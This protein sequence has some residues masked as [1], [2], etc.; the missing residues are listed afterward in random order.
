MKLK[1]IIAILP[2]AAL[3]A[4]TSP[5][6]NPSPVPPDPIEVPGEG[7]TPDYST[8]FTPSYNYDIVPYGGEVAA[9]APQ[10]PA[11]DDGL[12]P[13]LTPWKYIVDVK[14]DGLSTPDVR[15]QTGC[16]ATVSIA[17][18]DVDLNLGD[19]DYIKVVVHG[20]CDAGSLRISGNRRHMLQLNDLHLASTDRPAINDQN[21]KRVF[22]ELVGQT[23][24]ADGREYAAVPSGE[25]R[26][27]CFFAEGNVVV[28]GDGVLTLRGNYSHGFATDGF[29]FVNSGATLAVT[30]AVRNAIHVKGSSSE[31]NAF[32]GVEIVGGYV[33]AN[34]SAPRGKAM[35]SDSNIVIRGGEVNLNCSGDAA[36]D[37][38]DGSL[39]SAACIKSD[40][41]VQISGGAVSLTATGNGAKG[42][43][44][45]GSVT[46][47][48]GE[49]TVALSGDAM[50]GGGDSATPKGIKADGNMMINGGGNYVSARGIGGVGIEAG[51]NLEI[52]GGVTYTFGP[53]QGICCGGKPVY[54]GT[55]VLLAGGLRNA[56]FPG[57]LE[58][59]LT[60]VP[61]LTVS[62]IMSENGKKLLG[63]FRWPVAMKSASLIFLEPTATV[64]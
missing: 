1:K 43:K 33:Y 45:N 56:R 47:S 59:T 46:L 34:T 30:D 32:R 4:C 29:L 42:I 23:T 63:S 3:G 21:G 62:S 11:A 22:L 20:S 17:G 31:A 44:A 2:I 12:N 53:A 24:L 13:Q 54:N 7:F 41:T 28:C 37:P 58:Q 16:P 61:A 6:P 64:Q 26:K 39:S 38:D 9:D 19:A 5:N 27:G 51:F 18:C 52:N 14:F 35:K 25:D 55:G 50:Q 10:Y 36:I 48:G 40:L 15:M 8:T 60:D 49:L 57:M